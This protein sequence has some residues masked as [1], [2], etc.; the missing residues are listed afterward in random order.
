[1][2]GEQQ[3]PY[4]RD[5]FSICIAFVEKNR[6]LI[7]CQQRAPQREPFSNITEMSSR[8]THQ[9]EV[10]RLKKKR[11]MASQN[12]ALKN[13]FLSDLEQSYKADN[14]YLPEFEDIIKEK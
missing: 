13:D 3:Y 4:I 12:V 11:E 2:G 7:K 8:W 5:E 10:D 1:M 9:E 14:L 6:E